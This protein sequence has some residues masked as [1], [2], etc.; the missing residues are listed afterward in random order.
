MYGIFTYIYHQI[1]ANVGIHI[2]VPMDR[3][4]WFYLQIAMH[5]TNLRTVWETMKS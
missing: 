2:P 4:R 3:V 5:E 1:Q